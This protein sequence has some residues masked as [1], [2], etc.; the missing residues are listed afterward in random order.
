MQCQNRTWISCVIALDSRYQY[1]ETPKNIFLRFFGITQ[2]VVH[3][4]PSTIFLLFNDHKLATSWTGSNWRWHIYHK[5]YTNT[6][7]C[8][9]QCP[10]KLK[11]NVFFSA[12]TLKVVHKFPSECFLKPYLQLYAYD[13]QHGI[14]LTA[15]VDINAGPQ[16]T[17]AQHSINNQYSKMT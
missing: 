12:T 11:L 16:I 8:K 17:A 14:L 3:N 13:I 1:Y 4:S 5:F 10:Q 9:T 15:S 6:S 7:F 2:T